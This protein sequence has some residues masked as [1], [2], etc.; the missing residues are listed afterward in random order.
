MT[1]KI[2]NWTYYNK[3]GEV[4]ISIKLFCDTDIKKAQLL[5]IDAASSNPMVSKDPQPI[6]TFKA[7]KEGVIEI[8][9][10]VWLK[11]V[12][13]GIDAPINSIKAMLFEKFKANDIKCAIS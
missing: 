6:C 5:M 9:L 4:K 1:N 12:T 11:D 7:F 13:N 8:H 10:V 3:K 2:I